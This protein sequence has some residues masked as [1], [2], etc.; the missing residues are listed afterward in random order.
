MIILIQDRK[1]NFHLSDYT[2]YN[3]S[4]YTL[5]GIIYRKGQIINT[6]A[7]YGAVQDFCRTC[8]EDYEKLYGKT[9]D[10]NPRFAKSRTEFVI[11][12][13]ATT[14]DKILNDSSPQV[15]YWNLIEKYW[16]K[17]NRYQRKLSR[18]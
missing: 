17:L 11:Q 15:K 10:N 14:V 5:C 3:G 7:L 12:S 18:K 2:G 8:Y 13:Q 9:L 4:N 6:F 16:N 1:D